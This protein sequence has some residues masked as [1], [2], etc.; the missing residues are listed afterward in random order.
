ME[1][2]RHTLAQI[3]SG[4]CLACG[5]FPSMSYAGE[6]F[7][8]A[9]IRPR[10]PHPSPLSRPPSPEDLSRSRKSG[11]PALVQGGLLSDPE[12]RMIFENP[13]PGHLLAWLDGGG[14]PNQEI[15][16]PSPFGILPP[17]PMDN[18]DSLALPSICTPAWHVAAW[19]G[20]Q[21]AIQELLDRN[22]CLT[23]ESI[24]K[25]PIHAI[26]QGDIHTDPLL[27]YGAEI[28][29]QLLGNP[30][31]DPDSYLSL[32]EKNEVIEEAWIAAARAWLHNGGSIQKKIAG[33]L[34][35]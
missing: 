27:K 28:L 24:G 20:N 34:V 11:S 29:H 4:C 10:T 5:V 19:M 9:F 17:K 31:T 22:Y 15:T 13:S 1:K 35:P 18:P 32:I 12:I 33:L 26:L 2:L 23:M 21:K 8:P 25:E 3:A 30:H 14:D 6:Y 16:Y 7:E